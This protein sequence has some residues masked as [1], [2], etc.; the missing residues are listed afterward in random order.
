MKLVDLV[1]VV[2][3]DNKSVILEIKKNSSLDLVKLGFSGEE[4]QIRYTK[5]ENHIITIWKNDNKS[6]S[7]EFGANGFTL[8]SES[9]EEKQKLIVDCIE[10][11]LCINCK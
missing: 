8:I 9:L 11:D 3:N 5:G 10:K 4:K 7:W 6:Y 1:N 2:C